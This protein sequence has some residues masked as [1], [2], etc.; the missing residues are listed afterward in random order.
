MKKIAGKIAMI[1]VLVMLANT[2][3]SC[4]T[5]WTIDLIKSGNEFLA[6][7][8]ILL[9]LPCLVLDLI[10]LPAQPKRSV[11]ASDGEFLTEILAALPETERASAQEKI[12]SLSEQQLASVVKAIRALYALPQAD[13][14]LLADAARSLPETEQAFLK[15]T[16]SSLTDGEIAALADEISLIPAADM[17]AQINVLREAPSQDWGYRKYAAERFAA[18]R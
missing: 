13:R 1:L 12:N 10:T 11:Y 7:V 2:F 4:F 17:A 15:E 14:V 5:Q 3:A 6:V 16:A 8:G 9:F 18:G